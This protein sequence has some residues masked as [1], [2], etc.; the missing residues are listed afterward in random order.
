MFL[1]LLKENLP[2]QL[3]RNKIIFRISFSYLFSPAVYW[4]VILKMLSGNLNDITS[5]S[6]GKRH[7]FLQFYLQEHFRSFYD[8]V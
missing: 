2:L 6:T 5:A 7:H 8:Y 3:E 1:F 4:W